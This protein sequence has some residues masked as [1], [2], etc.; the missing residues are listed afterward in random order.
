[1][2]EITFE[3]NPQKAQTNERKHGISF[4]EAE[5]TFSDHNARVSYD[6]DHSEEEDRYLLLGM[7]ESLQLLVVCHAYRQN[8]ECIRII[9]A[10]RATTTE[11][12]QYQ[13]F[14]I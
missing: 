9:S 10:R 5:T 8:D 4:E 14:S 3:W 12:Q 7:S 2:D 6:L 1:M 13:G 11:Q